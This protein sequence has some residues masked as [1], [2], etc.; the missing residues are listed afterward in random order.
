M[1]TA[2]RQKTT[3]LS[4]MY[5]KVAV[6]VMLLVLLGSAL[7]LIFQIGSVRRQLT[8]G[9]WDQVPSAPRLARPV[10]LEVYK[11]SLEGLAR[12]FQMEQRTQRLMISEVRVS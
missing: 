2:P 12:P 3:W 8:Q 5:D 7:I 6:V 4:Q 1:S 9:Q 11:V 10:D